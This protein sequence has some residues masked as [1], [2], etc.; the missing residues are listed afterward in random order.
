[1]LVDTK[2]AWGSY[3]SLNDSPILCMSILVFHLLL[4]TILAPSNCQVE[5]EGDVM[6]SDLLESMAIL[7]SFPSQNTCQPVVGVKTT[8]W[9]R[10]G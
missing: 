6:I 1:M 4:F 2:K 7:F 3:K 10:S 5:A 8:R 9:G